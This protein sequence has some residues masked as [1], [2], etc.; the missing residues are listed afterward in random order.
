[1]PISR[2]HIPRSWLQ[3]SDNL[4]VIFE[5]TGGNPFDVSIKL[6]SANIICGQVSESHYP[7]LWKWSQSDFNAS[8][9]INDTTPELHLRCD[10]EHV[11]ASIKFAS[12][13]T[14]QGSCQ[15][16]SKGNCHAPNSLSVVSEVFLKFCL[17]SGSMVI[18]VEMHIHGT[19]IMINDFDSLYYEFEFIGPSCSVL[20][21]KGY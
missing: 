1:M 16:F 9:L 7:P 19:C 21:Y 17:T 13:G 10:D 12:Y 4:L 14:P 11:I 8:I 15:K 3:A 6:R 18:M 20:A 2:Y 5:E